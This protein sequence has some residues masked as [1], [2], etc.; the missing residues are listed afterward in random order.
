MAT[1]EFKYKPIHLAKI[2]HENLEHRLAT[3]DS[4]P[5]SS[6]DLDRKRGGFSVAGMDLSIGLQLTTAIQ[7]AFQVQTNLSLNNAGQWTLLATRTQMF[8]STG[9]ASIAGPSSPLVTPNT[10]NQ[11]VV[12]AQ[13]GNPPGGNSASN[14]GSLGNPGG[15]PI[16]TPIPTHTSG[17][18]NNSGSP[19]NGGPITITAGD[20]T[21][22]QVIQ[23]VSKG[24][25]QTVITN[26]ANG[27]II[28]NQA[29]MNITVNNAAAISQ[30]LSR[31]TAANLIGAQVSH[32]H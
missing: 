15:D 30:T 26:Q 21:T 11:F 2:D 24:G 14:I 32:P 13:S 7:G 20:P 9:G 6:S 8:P 29:L 22:T 5:L 25:V 28:N 3:L 10:Q 16:T 17:S 4:E 23:T 31:L 1:G 19:G 18:P 12:V 27:A